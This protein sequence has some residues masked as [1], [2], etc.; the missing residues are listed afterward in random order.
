MSDLEKPIKSEAIKV[1]PRMLVQLGATSMPSLYEAIVELLTNVDDSYE[2]IAY[3]NNQKQWLGDCRIEYD[4]GGKKNSTFLIIK[5]R[6]E[7]MNYA[8]LKNNFGNYGAKQ[9]G[10][11]TRGSAGRGAKDAAHIGDLT[12]E[13]IFNDKYSRVKINGHSKKIETYDIDKKVTSSQRKDIGTKKNGTKITLEIKADRS[14]GYHLKP[15]DLIE[16]IPCHFALSKILENKKN[17]LNVTFVTKNEEHK[18]IS[19]IPEGKLVYEQE[20][21]V[22][23]YKKYFGEDALVKFKLFKSEIA[24][25]STTNED[26]RFRQWGLLVMGKKAIHEKSLLSTEFDNSPE[27]KKYFGVLQTNLFDALTNDLDKHMQENKDFPEYNPASIFDRDRIEGIIYKHPA[28]Q[29]IFRIPRDVI[30]KQIAADRKLNEDKEISNDETKKLLNDIGKLCADLMEDLY[31]EENNEIEGI[32]ADVN[33]WV[34]IPP[35]IKMYAGEKR[36]IYVYTVKESLKAG[37]DF[38]YLKTKETSSL[39]IENEKVKYT[40][41][42]KKKNLI[43]F[44]FGVE[45]ILP[46]QNVKIDVHQIENMICTSGVIT[47]IGHENRDF[48][49][50][51]EFE[52]ENYSVKF[53]KTRAIK[54]FAKVPDV[55][56]ATTEAKVLN[57]SQ[58]NIKILGKLTF[59]LFEKTNYAIGVLN[60]RGE[61]ISK[62]NKITIQLN[63]KLCS[64]YIDVIP[65]EEEE[66]DKSQFKISIEPRDYGKTR[67]QWNTNNKNHLMI[68]GE[69]P[70]TKRYLGNKEQ[71]YP[72]QNTTLFKCLLAEI[73]SESMVIKRMT[74]NS[75]YDPSSYENILKNGSVEEIINKFTYRIEDEKL[76][77]L[78]PIHEKL[79]KDSLIKEDIRRVTPDSISK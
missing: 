52:K 72:G 15:K 34:I 31:E 21:Y 58:D 6:A 19:R 79:V 14:G 47:I 44:K 23:N 27:G 30:K 51:I 41:S 71:Y 7:G 22:N 9:S 16:K 54:I 40:I 4:L 77:F 68:A 55:I 69:H 53:N 2:R 38:A 35:K 75:R 50:E 59:E 17:T 29:E 12:V 61:N 78:I 56:N 20:Y 48:K 62:A 26:P 73:L 37:N 57:S 24:L 42:K 49:N 25:D 65:K 1:D 70:Q 10:T 13:S 3:S 63:G 74:L 18:L 66:D 32:N 45:A 8:S 43:Y 46:N 33:K 11:A 76:T 60:V 36:N 39:L 28:A 5:D 64:T 67:Y